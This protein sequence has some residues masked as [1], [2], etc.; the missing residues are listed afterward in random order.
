VLNYIGI[1]ESAKQEE[2]KKTVFVDPGY[3]DEPA[4]RETHLGSFI[5]ENANKVK[6]T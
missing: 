3:N 5:Q 6:K 4:K 2:E 1:A